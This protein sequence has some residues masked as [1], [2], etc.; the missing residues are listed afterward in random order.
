MFWTGDISNVGLD[1]R[2][3][4]FLIYVAFGHQNSSLG[5]YLMLTAS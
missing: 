1:L 2:F 4:P 3:K 5:I